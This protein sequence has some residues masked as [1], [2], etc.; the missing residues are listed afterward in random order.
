MDKCSIS[1]V[2]SCLYGGQKSPGSLSLC[3]SLNRLPLGVRLHDQFADK[4]FR[5]EISLSLMD[6]G[7]GVCFSEQGSDIAVF[8]VAAQA[9]EGGA[10]P[11]RHRDRPVSPG[12]RGL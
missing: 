8:D 11:E 9:L 4:T 3:P 5:L 10:G 7:Q 6:L 1:A 12:R 2:R